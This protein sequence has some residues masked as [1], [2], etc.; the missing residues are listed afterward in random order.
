M[1]VRK[2][3]FCELRDS[4]SPV[5]SLL[6]FYLWVN[7]KPL[8]YSAPIENEKTLNQRIVYACQNIRN[9]PGKSVLHSQ[10]CEPPHYAVQLSVTSTM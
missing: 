8:V 2:H 1:R 4:R 3:L 9:R 5:L 7:L 6:A 10:Q